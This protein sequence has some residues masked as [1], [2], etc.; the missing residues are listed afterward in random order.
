MVS[1]ACESPEILAAVQLICRRCGNETLQGRLRQRQFQSNQQVAF[2]NTSPAL[3]V[4]D[5]TKSEA[6]T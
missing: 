6:S 1:V 4:N 5:V 3:S 2:C